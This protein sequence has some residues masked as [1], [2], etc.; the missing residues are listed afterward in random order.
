MTTLRI[1]PARAAFGTIRT[2]GLVVG[3]ASV[4]VGVTYLVVAMLGPQVWW[5]GG[6]SGA[7]GAFVNFPLPLRLLNA[8][9]I[10]LWC[11]TVAG[12]AFV[13]ASLARNVGRGV[14]FVRSVSRAAWLLAIV[15]FVGS[16]MA[17]AVENIARGSSLIIDGRTDPTNPVGAPIGWATPSQAFGPD[18][19]LLGL[20]I[21]LGVLAYIITRGEDIQSD[22]DGTI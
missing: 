2:F 14:R 13:L 15:L 11:L 5:F 21:V 17:R 4:F 20:S 18:F 7:N 19:G 22:S 16:T 9:A 1:E 3:A 8:S 6:G 12:I 10:L